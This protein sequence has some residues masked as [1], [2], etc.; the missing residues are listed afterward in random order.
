MVILSLTHLSLIYHEHNISKFPKSETNYFV[1]ST[2]K[3]A[4]FSKED[5]G[6]LE[7]VAKVSFSTGKKSNFKNFI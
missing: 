2:E 5:N 7:N 4:L 6:Q 3:E 1:R